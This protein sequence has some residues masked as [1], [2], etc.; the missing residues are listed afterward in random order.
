MHFD[1]TLIDEDALRPVADIDLGGDVTLIETLIDHEPIWKAAA[2]GEKEILKQVVRRR[3]S[4]NHYSP[5]SL[6]SFGF[7]FPNTE[8]RMW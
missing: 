1:H 8:F 5:G 6:F 3:L 7:P 4:A 2:S